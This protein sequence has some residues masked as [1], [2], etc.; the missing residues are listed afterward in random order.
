MTAIRAPGLESFLRK[1]DPAIA[2]VLIYGDEPGAVR[3]LAARAV[4]KLA[5]SLDDPFAVVNLQDSDLSGDP[6]RLVDEVLSQSMFVGTRVVWLR[7]AGEAF[8]R[9][10]AALL[11]GRVS[12]NVVVAEAGTLAKSSN[13]RQLFEKSPH[14]LILPLYEADAGEAAGL[15][16]QVLAADGIRIAED[17][18]HRF[19]ELA[20]TSR[21]LVQREAEKLAL[22]S[23]GQAEAS[24]AD[25]EAICGNDTGAEPD[26]L[27]DSVM[28]GDVAATDRLFQDLVAGGEDSGRLLSVVHNHVLRLQDIKAAAERG[29]Q[30]AQLLRSVRPAIFFKRHDSFQ[31]QLRA[32]SMADLVK[33]ASTL[34]QAVMQTRQNAALGEA[35]ASRCLLSLARRGM[36]L[37]HDRS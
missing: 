37:R 28:S 29:G 22:Y 8:A 21:S 4:K 1:P 30:V 23:M 14:A 12:G 26:A 24:L 36:A 9:A 2:A 19:I 27:A 34:G 11:D 10:S 31:A 33:A 16:R 5:G 18:L 6:G 15:A 7:E 35:I 3:D 25:V 13:L 20:G 32:W 17:A